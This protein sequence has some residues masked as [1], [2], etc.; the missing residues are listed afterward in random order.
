MVNLL[1]VNWP[2]SQPEHIITKMLWLVFLASWLFLA[3]WLFGQLTFWRLT[4]SPSIWKN[5]SD[6]CIVLSFYVELSFLLK[7]NKNFNRFQKFLPLQFFTRKNKKLTSIVSNVAST[8]SAPAERASPTLRQKTSSGFDSTFLSML[9]VSASN[10]S[11]SSATRLS[12][13]CV[14]DNRASRFVTLPNQRFQIRSRR[15]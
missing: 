1:K 10:V 8:K 6:W 2:K 13:N 7:R 3:D 4:I 9:A 15:V 5:G 14:F 12:T 11:S